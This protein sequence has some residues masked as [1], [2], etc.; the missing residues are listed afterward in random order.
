VERSG[1]EELWRDTALDVY[2]YAARRV[3]PDLAEDWEIRDEADLPA[4]LFAV[5]NRRA[6]GA[7]TAFMAEP[8]AA[9][10][11]ATLAL[12]ELRDKWVLVDPPPILDATVLCN[13]HLN[14]IGENL[15]A[16]RCEGAAVRVGDVW[17][18]LDLENRFT[19]P[20]ANG[21]VIVQP[22]RLLIVKS[23]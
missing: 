10:T 8:Q 22:T 13:L 5:A 14:Y 2:L 19:F 1:I 7:T 9:E 17:S 12:Y 6:D 15:L 4:S 11:P 23:P 3:G 21:V 16:I 20:L 18:A